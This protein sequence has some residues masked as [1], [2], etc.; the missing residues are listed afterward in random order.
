MNLMFNKKFAGE[1][2][3]GERTGGSG[4]G[5]GLGGGGD[6]VGS[7]GGSRLGRTGAVGAGRGPIRR[8]R[9][10]GYYPMDHD[11]SSYTYRTH[12]FLSPPAGGAGDEPTERLGPGPRRNSGP[13]VIK[14]GGGAGAN[15]N[16]R[17]PSVN[18]KDECTTTTA[19][20]QV[21]SSIILSI[22]IITVLLSFRSK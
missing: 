17:K 20:R 19:S 7:G 11:H 13:H 9:E 18:Q 8:S 5:P 12:L 1:R 3:P 15:P 6:G 21:K 14:W 4:G 22:I 2:G 16:K 10:F